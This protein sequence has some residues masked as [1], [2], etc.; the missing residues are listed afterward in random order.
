MP[1]DAVFLRL[2]RAMYAEGVGPAETVLV[3]AVRQVVST[4]TARCCEAGE[5]KRLRLAIGA[6]VEKRFG[7]PLEAEVEVLRLPPKRLGMA[8]VRIGQVEVVL[9]RHP[10]AFTDPS[11][12]Q[13]CGIEPLAHKIVVVKEGYLFPGLS[14]IAPRHIMLLTPGSGDMRLEKLTYRRRRRPMY[15]LDPETIFEPEKAAGRL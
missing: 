2:H 9:C 5:G 1:V 10:V 7:P 4:A 12:F 11:Q 6:T 8:V 13:A 3:E 14:R 15:P